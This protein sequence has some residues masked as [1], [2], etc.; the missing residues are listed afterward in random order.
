MAD[1]QWWPPDNS[2]V[3]LQACVCQ[4]HP[5]CHCVW[6]ACM[7]AF[8]V[9]S[10]EFCA[11][12]LALTTQLHI[13]L[14][15]QLLGANLLRLTGVACAVSSSFSLMTNTYWLNIFTNG[16]TA[17]ALA[18]IASWCG[19]ST[20]FPPCSLVALHGRYLHASQKCGFWFLFLQTSTSKFSWTAEIWSTWVILIGNRFSGCGILKV[21]W[22]LRFY[23][24]D[25][26]CHMV[27]WHHVEKCKFTSKNSVQ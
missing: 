11:G 21:L 12:S 4:V 5:I 2:A 25:R 22:I 27:T 3:A 24:N 23:Q 16:S 19:S 14:R 9:A 18:H 20:A 8:K 13:Y 15:I 17:K 10:A 7:L 1:V 6:H 26:I